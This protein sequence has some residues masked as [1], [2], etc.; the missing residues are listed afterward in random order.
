MDQIQKA[1]EDLIAAIETCEE[2]KGYLAA[3]EE[4]K[5]HP[6]LKKK[7]DE[8]R[9]L[10]FDLQRSETDIFEKTDELR[11][12]H[13]EVN[14]NSVVWEYLIAENAFCRILRQVNWKLLES[15]DFDAEF[16]E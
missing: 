2:Y 9:K 5:K 11:Q 1:L 4:I 13:E 10:K 14:G 8:F 3:K 16:E 6:L 7:A 12:E 15:L